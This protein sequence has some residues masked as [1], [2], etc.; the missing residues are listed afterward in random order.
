MTST[1]TH[2]VFYKNFK[3]FSIDG[4][5]KVELANP[6]LMPMEIYLETDDDIE[7]RTNN[8]VNFNTWCSERIIPLDR[9]YAKELLAYY[10]YDNPLSLSMRAEIGIAT[11]CLSINDCFWV[12]KSDEKLT[13]EDVNLFENSLEN[14]VLEIPLLGRG[15]TADRKDISTPDIHT[16]GKAP[17]AWKRTGNSFFLLKRD[18]GNDSVT[19]EVEASEILR[20]IFGEKVVKYTKDS[21]AGHDVSVCK[22]FTDEKLNM[23]KAEYYAI[24]KM[25]RDEDI[26]S[27]LTGELSTEFCTMVIADYLV[28]NTDRHSRNWG[29]MYELCEDSD[30]QAFSIKGL[31]YLYDF[32][33]AFE[34]EGEDI[35]QP[36]ILLGKRI[37]MKDAACSAVKMLSEKIES[38]QINFNIDLSKYKY[39]EYVRKR[40]DVIKKCQGQRF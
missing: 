22:C 4:G 19:K 24:Y 38:G 23:V 36:H 9:K 33:H 13:W 37:S 28:G 16:D 34:S 21:F 12:K 1:I 3:V 35:C 6:D 40:I 39:G 25:N 2:E 7:S 17:K 5:G 8:I 11:R 30:E 15:F 32:D 14:T 26:V 31:S 18:N 20:E 27:E 29:M 10:G